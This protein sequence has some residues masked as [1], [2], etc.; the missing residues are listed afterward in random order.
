MSIHVF[1]LSANRSNALGKFKLSNS[2]VEI[3]PLLKCCEKCEYFAV[4]GYRSRQSVERL[5]VFQ[6]FASCYLGVR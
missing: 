6:C 3:V 2:C 1:W 4:S 5:G